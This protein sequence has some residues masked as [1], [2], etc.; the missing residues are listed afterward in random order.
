MKLRIEHAKVLLKDSNQTIADI[1]QNCGFFDQSHF[2]KHF[3]KFE[4]ITPIKYKKT[5]TKENA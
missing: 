2:S 4:N 5:F 1:A 3:Y